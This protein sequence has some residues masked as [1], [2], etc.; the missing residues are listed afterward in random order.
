[1]VELAVLGISLQDDGSVPV[2]LLHPHGSSLVLSLRIGPMEAFAISSAMHGRPEETPLPSGP[3]RPLFPRPLT[4]DFF[5]HCIHALGGT[6]KALEILDLTEGVF[7]AE[8]VLQSGNVTTRVDCRPSDGVALA[9][10]CG[11]SLWASRAV[12]AHAED[13]NLVLAGL[14]EYVRTIVEANLA[15]LA[16]PA[17]GGEKKPDR[18]PAAVEEALA[19]RAGQPADLVSV[20]RQMA[21]TEKAAR[22]PTFPEDG[23][24][25]ASEGPG[26]IPK[27][28]ISIVRHK[29]PGELA[30]TPLPAS[31]FSQDLLTALGLSPQDAATVSNAP[32]E[33]RWATLLHLL[34]PTTKVP[35]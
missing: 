25:P 23:A 20:A 9:L 29:K 11:A 28:R 7:L 31:E 26:S 14:P 35:M 13:I 33:K 8:A 27:I 22:L 18:M 10:R 4:H 19:A 5:M 1:M 34:A 3:G 21:E 30:E 24:R 15:A 16:A 2:L 12:L 32:E 17:P 6:F